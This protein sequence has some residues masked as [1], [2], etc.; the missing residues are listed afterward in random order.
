M[1]T[2]ELRQLKQQRRMRSVLFY[3]FVAIFVVIVAG[4][5]GVVFFNLGHPKPHE[6]EILFSVFIGE[7]G[8]A[9]LA[10][11]KVLFG[12]KK[13][14]A[15]LNKP[16]PVVKGDYKYEM[17]FND[18]KLVYLGQCNIK[19]DKMVL[20]VTGERQK[21]RN[22]RKKTNVSVHWNSNWAELCEDG[23]IRLDYSINLN[24]GVRGFAILSGNR[25]SFKEMMGEF[26][27]LHEPYKC[28]T[29]KLK[30]A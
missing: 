12:L 27:L 22:G 29:V 16:V 2:A 28:G 20:T 6:R 7:I 21:T 3:I 24:G 11:F 14:E 17:V 30:R 9:V 19:Q 1:T 25:S 18:N 26:H 10:L 15:A 8:I 5:I 23:K 13:P 4:T